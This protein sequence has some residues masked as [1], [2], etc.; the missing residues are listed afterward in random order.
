MSSRKVSH[1]VEQLL[2]CV[3]QPSFCTQVQ[4]CAASGALDRGCRRAPRPSRPNAPSRSG[5]RLFYPVPPNP[6]AAAFVL[7][8]SLALCFVDNRLSPHK[9]LDLLRCEANQLS[10]PDVIDPRLFSGR[11]DLHLIY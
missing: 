9:F 3:G 8:E 11:V 5:A 6:N 4:C 2:S 1:L 10:G 7:V